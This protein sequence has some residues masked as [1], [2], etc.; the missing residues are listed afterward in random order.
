MSK[1]IFL[2][3]AVLA[4]CGTVFAEGHY[5]YYYREKCRKSSMN[6]CKGATI[7]LCGAV[8]RVDAPNP[9]A[10]GSSDTVLSGLFRNN[11]IELSS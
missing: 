7:H 6:P 9:T 11:G 5:S 3:L 1:R 10:A 4:G 8:Y 2:M